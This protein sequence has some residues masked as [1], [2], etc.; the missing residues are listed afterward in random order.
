MMINL[1]RDDPAWLSPKIKLL[2]LS[3]YWKDTV[4]DMNDLNEFAEQLKSKP[5]LQGA[6]YNTEAEKALLVV[7]GLQ[8]PEGAGAEYKKQMKKKE[9]S[10][11][12]QEFFIPN[13][14]GS[15]LELVLYIICKHY[16]SIDIAKQVK[17]G[18]EL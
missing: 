7:S 8:R 5:K 10:I 4:F 3:V 15:P 1:I 16:C 6:D 18:A 12:T 11:G 17:A 13:W 2:K 14:K 9:S